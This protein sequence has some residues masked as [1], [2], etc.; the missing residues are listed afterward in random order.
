MKTIPNAH[1]RADECFA[2][3][4]HHLESNRDFFVSRF[5][6]ENGS[7][8]NSARVAEKFIATFEQLVTTGVKSQASDPFIN[9]LIELI[10]QNQLD[11]TQTCRLIS[12][13][14]NLMID[15][16]D[17]NQTLE[18]QVLHQL[19]HY[20]DDALEISSATFGRIVKK[21]V[22]QIE[23]T[24]KRKDYFRTSKKK[25]G[26]LDFAGI[27]MCMLDISGNWLNLWL[28]ISLFAGEDTA[29]RVFF[30]SG[31]AEVFS[32]ICLKNGIITNHA[33]GFIK[34]VDA[35]SE[36][37]FGDFYI[38]E[39][40]FE[41]GFARITCP[42]T[43][44]G[45]SFAKQNKTYKS[46]FCFH[47][48][49]VLLSF[50]KTLTGKM[51]LV[52]EEVNCIAKGDPECEF[53]IGTETEL[54][55]RNIR[56]TKW[57]PTMKEK[58]KFLENMLIEKE[59]AEKALIQKYDE[60]TV[61]NQIG[62]DISQSLNLNVI[63]NRSVHN[64]SRI[65]KNKDVCIYLVDRKN[66]DLIFKAQKGFSKDFFKTLSRVKIGEGLAGNAAQ[67]L[68]PVE[69]YDPTT[70]P[71]RIYEALKKEKVKS[72]LSVPLRT[73]NKVIGVMNIAAKFKHR[74]TVEE[75]NLISLI[76]SQ[77]SVAIEKA[78][79]LGEIRDSEKKYRTL[80]ENI[81]DGYFLCQDDHVLYA[82][83]AF[84]SMHGYSESE[85][86][87]KDFRGFLPEENV[88]QVERI[89]SG[90]WNQEMPEHLEF[91][92]KHKNTQNL[93]TDL[94]INL[95]KFNGKPAL[96]CIFRD[97]SK[98]K[99]MEKKIAE[100]QRLSSI[101]QLTADIAHEIRNPLSSIKTNIQVLSNKLQLQGFN[102]R[103]MEIA[104]EEILRLDRILQDV[105]NFSVP[106]KMEMSLDHLHNVID[107]CVGLI[108]EKIRRSKINVI[109]KLSRDIPQ[110]KMNTGMFQQV[111]LN[112]FLN[113]IDAM[114]HGGQI[115]IITRRMEIENRKMIFLEIMD[116][117]CGIKSE[118]LNR[119][120]DPFFSTKTQGAGLGL[121]NVKKII[122]AHHGS[123]E[124][125]NRPNQGARIII[126][127]PENKNAKSSNC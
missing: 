110:I 8:P 50:M 100:H 94:K 62:R 43:F 48:T 10:S 56:L 79:L 33:D 84:L 80:V 98:R 37:G 93:P 39:L 60:L 107:K 2:G 87:G 121:S 51:D 15:F 92:R 63:L 20:L 102:K 72:I 90:N 7:V 23:S 18:K 47:S 122:D 27:R 45:W 21:P 124:I 44:E 78:Y 104:V 120:F 19:N 95:T 127:L 113:A 105:L 16:L 73:K 6:K 99:E 61:I 77:I 1:D 38:K 46:P 13:L 55:K 101:G 70:L 126:K 68:V 117:G 65:L 75:I 29:R 26:W 71:N 91:K 34:A 53:V 114:P 115:V 116:S 41:Q 108:H 3:I 123:V 52:A 22:V 49:G 24:N 5:S 103:R 32:Q 81:N 106:V 69:C 119:V 86:L 17:L 85:V 109:Q 54:R 125:E 112:L 35:Y 76:G 111:I 74:F 89:L 58:A 14:R 118:N 30:E 28:S 97:I 82:N 4:F 42:D 64:L 66:K 57:G 25:R 88:A 67:K 36:A 12:S 11:L 96:I 40:I 31:I 9:G 59:N 83:T